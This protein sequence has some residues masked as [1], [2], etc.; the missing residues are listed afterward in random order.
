MDAELE[1]ALKAGPRSCFL[2]AAVR[3]GL[4]RP[5]DPIDKMQVDF[6]HEIVTLCARISDRYS[7]PDCIEDTIGDVIRAR[8][9]EL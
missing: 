2:A 3:A 8:L 6:A 5:G 1:A 4:I 7:N 9:F